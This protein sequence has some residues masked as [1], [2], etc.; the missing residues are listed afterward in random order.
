MYWGTKLVYR[1]FILFLCFEGTYNTEW[2]IKETN[3]GETQDPLKDVLVPTVS[4]NVK[5][6]TIGYQKPFGKLILLPNNYIRVAHW[7][8]TE[9]EL[10]WTELNWTELNWTELNWT[11]LNWMHYYTIR[12]CG[13]HVYFTE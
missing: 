12:T 10:N 2:T 6:K 3:N 1:D 9:T 13:P 5:T 7:N 8:W 11:E 4:K